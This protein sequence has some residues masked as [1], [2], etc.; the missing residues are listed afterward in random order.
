MPALPSGGNGSAVREDPASAGS[1]RCCVFL[2]LRSRR[3]LAAAQL[4]LTAEEEIVFL[5]RG[6]RLSLLGGLQQGDD[7]AVG[8]L[9]QGAQ[10][11]IVHWGLLA[12]EGP[13]TTSM[14]LSR[15]SKLASFSSR[16][17]KDWA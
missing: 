10:A 16:G 12:A 13:G 14:A 4:E 9:D 15:G 6:R 5:R 1:S 2:R 7:Q 11:G 3:G 8:L 17:G